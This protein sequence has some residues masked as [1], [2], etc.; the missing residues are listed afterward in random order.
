MTIFWICKKFSGTAEY[1]TVSEYSTKKSA[2]IMENIEIKLNDYI[3]NYQTSQYDS[4]DTRNIWSPI[5]IY[6]S[7]EV[8]ISEFLPLKG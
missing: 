1:S 3:L 7:N 6:I 8:I 5:K 2:Q 4:D